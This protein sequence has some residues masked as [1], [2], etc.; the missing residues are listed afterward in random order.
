MSSNPLGGRIGQNI[1][2]MLEGLAEVG[3]AECR[4]NNQGQANGMS[5]IGN[6]LN[7]KDIQGRIGAGLGEE[8]ARL[9]IGRLGKIGRIRAIDEADFNAEFWH[10]GIEHAAKYHKRGKIERSLSE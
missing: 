4:V 8:A 10:Q 9:V 1:G 5:R 7:V 6:G 2:A 3:R